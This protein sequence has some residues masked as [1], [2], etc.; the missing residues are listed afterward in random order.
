MGILAVVSV[1]GGEKEQVNAKK[2]VEAD[3]QLEKV[4][5]VEAST[6]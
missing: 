5:R 1:V 4:L 3:Q 6:E 2:D